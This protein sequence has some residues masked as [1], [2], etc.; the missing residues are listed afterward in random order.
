MRGHVEYKCTG[1]GDRVGYCQWCDGG[2][3]LCTV[4]DGAEGSLPTECPG[5]KMTSLESDSVY[6]GQ[7]DFKDGEWTRGNND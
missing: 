3:Y 2:L 4:C 1:C 7:I 6:A 5:R